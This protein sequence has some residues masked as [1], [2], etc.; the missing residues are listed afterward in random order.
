[1]RIIIIINLSFEININ[2]FSMLSLVMD[3]LYCTC[4]LYVHVLVHCKY[5]CTYQY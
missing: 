2:M 3:I 4:T 5:T 1:M